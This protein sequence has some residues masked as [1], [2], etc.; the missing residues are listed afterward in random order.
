[1]KGEEK[2]NVLWKKKKMA[3]RLV[4]SRILISLGEGTVPGFGNVGKIWKY[5]I[6]TLNILSTRVLY[7]VK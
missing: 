3:G 4:K 6:L 5:N 2:I 7:I 1:M